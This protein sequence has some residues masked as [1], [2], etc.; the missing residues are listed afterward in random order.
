[1]LCLALLFLAFLAAKREKQGKRNQPD[2]EQVGNPGAKQGVYSPPSD[3]PADY[4]APYATPS[5]SGAMGGTPASGG[6][7]QTPPGAGQPSSGGGSLAG[8]P[9]AG[10]SP[11][12][13][14]AD[15]RS[16]LKPGRGRP[17]TQDTGLLPADQGD[18]NIKPDD[19]K[20]ILPGA[21]PRWPG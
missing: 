18:P 11:F 7:T 15:A 6:S 9:P 3:P 21:Q 2:Y 8:N 4:T 16:N 13:G 12:A 17:L 20:Y 14:I 19:N 5:G 1:L 10:G